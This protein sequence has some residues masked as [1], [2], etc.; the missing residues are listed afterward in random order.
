MSF[1]APSTCWA[2]RESAKNKSGI[3]RN[4]FMEVRELAIEDG[5]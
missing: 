5:N 2:E 1:Q 3:R 4:F